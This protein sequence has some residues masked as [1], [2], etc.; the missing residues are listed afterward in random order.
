MWLNFLN[1]KDSMQTKMRAEGA[2]R[3][4]P[5]KRVLNKMVLIDRDIGGHESEYYLDILLT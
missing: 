4:D 2:G 3:A 5:C 1:K